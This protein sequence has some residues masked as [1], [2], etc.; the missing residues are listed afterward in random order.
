MH[1]FGDVGRRTCENTGEEA[2]GGR[3]WDE[4]ARSAAE[5]KLVSVQKHHPLSPGG[6]ERSEGAGL[7]RGGYTNLPHHPVAAGTR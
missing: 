2:P 5:S 4:A 6:G 7:G 3:T 1:F